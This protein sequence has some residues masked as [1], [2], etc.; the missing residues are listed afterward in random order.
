MRGR[1]ARVLIE[2]DTERW[3]RVCF[4]S[5][6]VYWLPF[7]MDDVAAGELVAVARALLT[8][9]LDLYGDEAPDDAKAAALSAR[10]LSSEKVGGGS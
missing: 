1:D 6:D 3:P 7:G 4:G 2:G 9:A 8:A 5:K 10:I